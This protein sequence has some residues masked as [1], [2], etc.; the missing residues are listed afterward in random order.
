MQYTA[1]KPF[2]A[3]LIVQDDGIRY[4]FQEDHIFKDIRFA[5]VTA[6]KLRPEYSFFN[7]FILIPISILSYSAIL[8]LDGYSNIIMLILLFW[9]VLGGISFFQKQNYIVE[10]HKG[11]LVAEVFI[12]RNKKEAKQIKKEIESRR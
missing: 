5:Q 7:Q 12:T 9:G 4:R 8:Y 1:N 3:V 10:V 2:S 11:P 6:I